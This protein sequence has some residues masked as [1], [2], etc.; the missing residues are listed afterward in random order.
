MAS[1][2]RVLP[3]YYKTL[4]VKEGNYIPTGDYMTCGTDDPHAHLLPIKKIYD[5]NVD[6]NYPYVD[7]S[8]KFKF[9]N[10]LYYF[11]ARFVVDPLNRL[12]YGFRLKGMENLKKYKE[13]LKG[14]ALTICNHVF[15]WDMCGILKVCG[16]R[17]L[18]FPIFRGQMAGKDRDRMVYTGGVPIPE[19]L[20]DLRHFYR[21]FDYYHE[22]G[23]WMHFFPEESRWQFYTPIRPFK[24]GAF[25]MAER[26]NVPIIP[27]AYSYRERKGILKLFGKE[28]CVTLNVGEPIFPD[29]ALKGQ[30]SASID[31]LRRRTHEACVRLAGIENNP[32]TYNQTEK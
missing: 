24:K 23:F 12:R 8:F 29:P 19:K 7:N 31:D 18:R 1:E 6:A 15:R 17:Q 25:I 11:Q 10:F 9:F 28:A 22:H 14:G 21:A 4:K 30:R 20:S 26:Y 32:W 5:V 16:W 27:M 13:Q 3:E 2:E